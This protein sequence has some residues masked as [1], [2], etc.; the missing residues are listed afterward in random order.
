VDAR[1]SVLITF[2]PYMRMCF[3]IKEVGSEGFKNE[4]IKVM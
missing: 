3:F 4:E 1:G 2:L